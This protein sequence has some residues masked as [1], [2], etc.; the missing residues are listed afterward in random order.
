MI[1]IS[2]KDMGKYGFPMPSIVNIRMRPG[3]RLGNMF[4]LPPA[5]LSTR[6]AAR[7]A[8]ITSVL[9]LC[10]KPHQGG[11]E[12]GRNQQTRLRPYPAPF[13]RHTSPAEGCGSSPDPGTSRPCE[14]GN[15]DDLYPC[16]EGYAEPGGEP[17][18]P[19][20]EPK[21]ARRIAHVAYRLKRRQPGHGWPG[22]RKIARKNSVSDCRGV[23][24]A[25]KGR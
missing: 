25:I 20:V 8:A 13:L 4:F 9:T 14:G 16:G 3:K 15:D 24:D 6:G 11:S 2:Q 23:R 17:V 7:S 21:R 19:A 18:R 10:K 5:D 12:K 1:A 22:C